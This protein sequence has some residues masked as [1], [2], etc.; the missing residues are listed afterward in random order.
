MVSTGLVGVSTNSSRRRRRDAPLDGVEI[1]GVH[2]GESQPVP[3]QHLVEEPERAAVRVVGDD[4]VIAGGEKRRRSR[5]WPPCPR[6]TRARPCRPRSRRGWLRAPR[7]SGSACARTRIPCARRARA[8][9]R[10]RSGR[11]GVMMAPVDGSGS[12]PAWMQRVLNRARSVELHGGAITISSIVPA[13]HA[14]HRDHR[15]PSCREP[16]GRAPRGTQSARRPSLRHAGAG[17]ALAR[18]RRRPLLASLVQRVVGRQLRH[19]RHRHGRARSR[20]SRALA[21]FAGRLIGLA[22]RRCSGASAGS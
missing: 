21:Y 13:V 9:R 8:A 22:K 10:W 19:R 4:D 14:C 3:P 2:V 11:S 15:H 20:C 18:R 16:A 1:A 6:R 7:A 17:R 12:W 5:R